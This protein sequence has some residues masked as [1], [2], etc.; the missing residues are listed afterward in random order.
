M[1]MPKNGLRPEAALMPK[2]LDSLTSLRFF[3]AFA[4]FA[5]HFTGLGGQTGFGRA[6]AIFPFSGIG[7]HGVNPTMSGRGTR[8]LAARARS[9]RG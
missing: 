9:T 3:A 6:P 5:H 1:P 8:R 2:R 4:V 7:G